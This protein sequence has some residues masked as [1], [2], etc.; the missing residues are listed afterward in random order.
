MT[1]RMLDSAIW[2]NEKFGVMPPMARLLAIGIINQADDQG[3]GKAH[4]VYLRSQVFPYDDVTA[5]QVAE[6]LAMVATNETILL[7]QV[8]GK[9]YYQIINW[10]SYQSH[11]YAMPSQYP[12]PDGWKDRIR[13][14]LT[15]GV[16]ITC[17]WIT[18]DGKPSPDTCDEQGLAIQVNNQVNVKVNDQVKVQDYVKDKDKDYDKDPDFAAAVAAWHSGGQMLSKTI[19]DDIGLAIDDWRERGY[20]GYVADAITEAARQ[21]KLNWK[22]VEAILKRCALENVAPTKGKNGSDPKKPIITE[23]VK[24][25][26]GDGTFGEVE[27]QTRGF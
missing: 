10:W 20:P 13:K 22:Y 11:Q 4:P 15:K 1:R 2:K 26:Y 9:D 3:R 12:K 17:N 5:G 27:V 19:A 24:L 7:Y 25:D 8:D 23:T 21:G 16:I 18:T 14:T 6:W